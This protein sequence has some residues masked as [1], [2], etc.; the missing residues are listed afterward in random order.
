MCFSPSNSALELIHEIADFAQRQV[1][2]DGRSPL[3]P[4]RLDRPTTVI[5]LLK[6]RQK[7]V[8]RWMADRAIPRVAQLDPGPLLSLGCMIRPPCLVDPLHK[9]G[10]AQLG[11]VEAKVQGRKHRCGPALWRPQY[12]IGRREDFQHVAPDKDER[13]HAG[14]PERRLEVAR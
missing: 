12:I 6:E 2:V 10:F 9:L 14:C 13:A 4:W 11:E 8:R 1:H 7:A 3:E 5:A